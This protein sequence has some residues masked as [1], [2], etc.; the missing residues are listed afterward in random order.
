MA[1][2]EWYTLHVGV[3][4]DELADIPGEAVSDTCLERL[5]ESVV[6]QFGVEWVLALWGV[7]HFDFPS[8]HRFIGVT[9]IQA[10]IVTLCGSFDVFL[11]D[12]SAERKMQIGIEVFRNPAGYFCSECAF[13]NWHVFAVK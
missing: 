9:P 1:L 5:L 6:N 7:G 4:E 11:D 2:G 8:Q 12:G 3:E 13:V 10:E